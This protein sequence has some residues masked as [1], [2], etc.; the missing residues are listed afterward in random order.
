MS[1]M[2][3]YDG[4]CPFCSKYVQLTRLRASAGPVS[5]VDLRQDH[6]AR[7]RFT[8]QGID[9]DQGMVVQTEGGL[10]HGADAM[11]VI[12]AMSSKSG[13][14]N[15]AAAMMFKNKL[16]ANTVY[17]FLRAG[18]NATLFLMG[19]AAMRADDAAESA[20][21]N[22]FARFFGLFLLLHVLY[23]FF[24]AAPDRFEPTSIPLLILGMALVVVPAS[25][26]VFVAALLTVAADSWLH[27]P[28]YSNHTMLL[29]VLVFTFLV[30]G[31]WHMLRGSSFVQYFAAVRP[32]G[33]ALLLTMYTFGIF[34]KINSD[35][36][37]PVSSCA[38]ALWREMPP[39]LVWFDTPLIHTLA[40]YGTFAVEGVIMLMLIVPRWRHWGI[41]F[42]VGFHALLA[43]SGFAMYPVF[44]TLAIMLH[45]LFVPPQVAL[46]I[47]GS[48]AYLRLDAFLRRPAGIAFVLTAIGVIG[49]YAKTAD[50]GMVAFVWLLLAA[51]PLALVA[52]K[53]YNRTTDEQQAAHLWSPTLA[54]NIIPLLFFL[55][56]AAP[57]FGL[58]TA[59]TMNMFSNLRLENGESNHL[60][61]TRTI[62]PFSYLDDVAFITEATGAPKLQQIAAY[63][64]T[65]YVYYHLLDM[66]ERAPHGA[67]IAY[68]LGDT[69]T[70]L[71]PVA[72]I[73]ARD[74]D[75]LHPQWMRKFFHFLP[76]ELGT[77]RPC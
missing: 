38:V 22:L 54:L 58:K 66:L 15:R 76:V 34:H 7:K 75:M 13:I 56:C 18:R 36:L 45:I 26:P 42:G 16:L 73:L 47:T 59:Q 17:P 70:P 12:S 35:F 48:A 37:N 67:Q 31:A 60:V 52:L 19:R 55:N 61:F 23:N 25:R 33:C 40:I 10:F 2:I 41:C 27:A 50:Y 24:R 72:D 63:P 9:P 20:L 6:S 11:H 3:Y 46:R 65:G 5:L 28:V 57:Y 39:P 32:V 68:T 49:V 77:P 64:G 44:T 30:G 62:G 8:D 14:V 53:G 29:N 1:T 69:T 74:G 71:M 51:W 43:L 4:D 21:F